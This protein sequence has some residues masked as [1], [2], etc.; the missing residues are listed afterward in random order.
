M[1]VSCSIVSDPFYAVA[2]LI[3]Q[4]IREEARRQ[5]EELERILEDNRKKVE[6]AQAAATAAAQAA[7]AG[8]DGDIRRSLSGGSQL[9]RPPRTSGGLV[10]VE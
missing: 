3:V 2:D 7:A 1:I 8:A 9:G 4:Q 6:A 5:Q 10:L